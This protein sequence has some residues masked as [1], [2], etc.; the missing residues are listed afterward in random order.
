MGTTGYDCI[1]LPGGPCKPDGTPINL[2]VSRQCGRFKKG[3]AAIEG[4]LVTAAVG[5]NQD[6]GV[7]LCSKLLIFVRV[8]INMQVLL[9]IS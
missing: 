7:T 4:G 8:N 2:D 1:I 9:Y 6:G 3:G 5:N